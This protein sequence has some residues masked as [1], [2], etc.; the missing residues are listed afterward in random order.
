[1]IERRG[2]DSPL[3]MLLCL[4][5]PGDQRASGDASSMQSGIGKARSF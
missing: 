2:G 1:M 5:R 3:R 4:Q